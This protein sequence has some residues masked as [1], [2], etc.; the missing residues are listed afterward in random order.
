MYIYNVLFI[1]CIDY[2]QEYVNTKVKEGDN[3]EDILYVEVGSQIKKA[4]LH[5]GLTQQELSDLINLTRA[6]V[7][8]I[9]RGSQKLSLL[10]LYQ[11]AEVLKVSP[12]SLLPDAES[13]KNPQP[14][15]YLNFDELKHHLSS[16]EFEMINMLK[17]KK[18]GRERDDY[19]GSKKS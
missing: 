7:A 17:R 18:E 4:R 8:N 2:I 1:I 10:N 11:I 6:S 19:E 14:N 13:L 16:E 15:L 12:Q 5:R 3:M 9:E